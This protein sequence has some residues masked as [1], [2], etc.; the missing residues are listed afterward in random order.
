MA[1][2]NRSSRSGGYRRLRT[3]PRRYVPTPVYALAEDLKHQGVDLQACRGPW[4]SIRRPLRRR[5]RNAEREMA[6]VT[7]GMVEIPVDTTER[8]ADLAGFLNLAGVN[9][10]D[11]IPNLRAPDQDLLSA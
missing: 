7:N 6:I 3:P 4:R 8:A 9:H 1:N 2:L 5:G 11:P 10:L